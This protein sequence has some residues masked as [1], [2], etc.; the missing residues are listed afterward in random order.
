MM[1]RLAPAGLRAAKPIDRQA[2]PREPIGNPAID[3]TQPPDR[4]KQA[5][6]PAAPAPAATTELSAALAVAATTRG[7]GRRTRYRTR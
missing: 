5:Q 7:S 6:H 2:S 3:R 1:I 4:G